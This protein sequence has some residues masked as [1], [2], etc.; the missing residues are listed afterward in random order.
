MKIMQVIGIYTVHTILLTK[1]TAAQNKVARSYH[2][3]R[4]LHFQAVYFAAH[5]LPFLMINKVL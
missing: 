2:K 5:I 3:V 1:I 4:G